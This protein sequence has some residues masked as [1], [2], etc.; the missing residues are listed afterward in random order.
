MQL[1]KIGGKAIACMC[2]SLSVMTAMPMVSYA[3]VPV[4]Q[5]YAQWDYKPLIY[6]S[7]NSDGEE[8]KRLPDFDNKIKENEKN[9]QDYFEVKYTDKV[10]NSPLEIYIENDKVTVS[11]ILSLVKANDREEGDVTSKVRV[12]KIEYP[13]SKK[14]NYKPE[15]V[16]NPSK[17]ETVDTY[18][19]HLNKDEYVDIKVTYEVSDSGGN[20]TQQYGII[21]VKY[22]N[23]PTLKSDYL[24]YTVEELAERGDEIL[25]EIK[26]NAFPTDIEDDKRKLKLTPKLIDPDPL[27]INYIKDQ[28]SHYVTYT[29]TD[30]GGK[31]ATSKAEIYITTGDPYNL[32]S[33]KSTRFISHKYMYTISKNSKWRKNSE[34]WDYLEKVLKNNES[35]HPTVKYTYTFNS[36]DYKE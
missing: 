9:E 30:S 29:V 2:L 23:P 26:T 22:N 31:S 34:L 13:A 5:N 11:D 6:P 24:A 8:E 20:T 28:G 32:K 7:K 25:E 27:T 1:R 18:F 14:D 35:D 17:T 15:T 36:G 19:N 4:D 12:G 3:E 33:K 21:R 10:S 16:L